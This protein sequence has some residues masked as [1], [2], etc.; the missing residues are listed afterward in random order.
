MDTDDLERSASSVVLPVRMVDGVFELAFGA[1]L[2]ALRDGA[3]GRLRVAASAIT[4]EELRWYL[5]RQEV[6]DFLPSGTEVRMGVNP[7]R[8][9]KELRRHLVSSSAIF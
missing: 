4:N 5:E 3:R 2:P 9:P 7:D 1:P 6:V 8:V